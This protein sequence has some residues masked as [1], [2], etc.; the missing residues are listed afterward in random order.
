MWKVLGHF[1]KFFHKEEQRN[2]TLDLKGV[3]RSHAFLMIGNI[4]FSD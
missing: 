3:N 1:E 2:E 4:A